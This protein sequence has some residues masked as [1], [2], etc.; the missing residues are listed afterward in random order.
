MVETDANPE[1]SHSWLETWCMP[2]KQCKTAGHPTTNDEDGPT[3]CDPKLLDTGTMEQEQMLGH[4]HK[5]TQ[6]VGHVVDASST[7]T[8]KPNSRSTESS[9]SS[10]SCAEERCI[11]DRLG[12]HTRTTTAQSWPMQQTPGSEKKQTC[13]LPIR[14]P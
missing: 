7:S 1:M 9:D 4:V 8:E 12:G 2:L 10:T 14:K 13:T 11:Q 6:R 5:Q 3:S